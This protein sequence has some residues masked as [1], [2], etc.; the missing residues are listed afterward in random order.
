[1]IQGGDAITEVPPNR[2][3]LQSFY[4]PN[5]NRPG[6]TTARWG[7]FLDSID[8][9]DAHFFGI[10]PREA[11]KADPQQRLLLEVAYEAVEDAGL[12]L[13]Q[14]AGSSAGVFVGIS[15]F[16]YSVIQAAVTE[17]DEIDAYT[18]LGA[19]L[20]IAANRLSYFFDLHGPSLAVDTACS[21][22]LMATHLACQSLWRGETDLAVVGGVNAMLRPEGTMGFSKAG[23]LALDGHCKSFD[24]RGDGYVRAEGVGVLVLRPLSRALAT[25]EQIYAVI[26][27]TAA[28]QDGRTAG[29]AVPSGAAHEAMFRSALA[30][31]GFGPETVQY[32][33]AHGT[34]T[35]VGDPIEAIALG[36]VYGYGRTGDPCLIG[37]VKGN[38]GHLEA[39]AG[40]TGFIKAAIS[41]QHG[42]IPATNGFVTPNPQIPFTEL[43]LRVCDRLEPWP[44]TNGTPRRAAVSS[45]G[46]GGTNAHVIL[47]AAPDI[48]T[49]RVSSETAVDDS[50]V[51][52]LPL[53]GREVNAVRDLAAAYRSWLLEDRWR[54]VELVD[55]CY[56]ATTRRSQYDHRAAFVVCSKEELAEHLEAFLADQLEP[57]TVVGKTVPGRAL[58]VVFVCSGMGQ[59]WHA[60]GRQLIAEETVYREVASTIDALLTPLTGWSVLDELAQ[61]EPSSR[62]QHADVAQ[63]AIFMLQVGLAALWRSWGIEPAAIVGHSVGEVAA[64]HIAGAL[65]L[66]DAVQVIYHRSRL[67][68][69]VAGQ[70]TMLAVDLSLD[71]AQQIVDLYA[72]TVSMAAINAPASVTLSGEQTVLEVIEKRLSEG[73]AIC[74]FLKV[75]VPYH[76]PKMEP[77]QA[78][79]VQTLREI[80]PQAVHT[81]LFSTVT[82][83]ALL[84]PEV[85]ADYWWRNVRQPVQFRAAMAELI[86][87]K[88]RVF[89]E[90]GG[91]PVLRSA[92]AACLTEHTTE[93]LV[94][95]S[96]RRS[97]EERRAL[98]TSLGR[99]YLHGVRLDGRLY[100]NGGRRV[101]LPPYPW[102]RE[103]FW[104]E[105]T[106]SRNERLGTS[107]HPLLGRRVEAP[108]PT[109]QVDL[110]NA[111]L[112]YLRDHQVHSAVLFPAAGY[113][114]MALAAGREAFGATACVLEDIAYERALFLSEDAPPKTQVVLNPAQTEFEVFVR[115][116]GS[117]TSWTSHAKGRLR[118]AAGETPPAADIAVIRERC[119]HRIEPSVCY[120][121][122]RAIGLEY[123]PLFRGITAVW[124]GEREAFAEIKIAGSFEDTLGQYRVHPALLDACFQTLLAAIPESSPSHDIRQR[125]WLPEQIERLRFYDRPGGHA[126][127]HVRLVDIGDRSLRGDIQ[128]LD[129]LGQIHVGVEGFMC[130]AVE[131]LGRRRTG[132]YEYRW[133]LEPRRAEAPAGV[134]ATVSPTEL[135]GFL[136]E[137]VGRQREQL[138]RDAFYEQF[139]PAA[140]D[141]AAAYVARA[142]RSLG[143]DPD[144][145]N[146][147]PADQLA[148]ELGIVAQQRRQFGWLLRS[149]TPDDRRARR[150]PDQLWRELWRRFPD[151]HCELVLVRQCGNNL[152]GVLSGIADPTVVLFGDG[153]AST[154]EQLYQDSPTTRIYNRLMQRAVCEVVERFPP[155]LLRVLEIGAG[156]GGLTAQLLPLFQPERTRFVFSDISQLF[157]AQA[158]QR[159]RDSPFL[160][161]RVVDIEQDPVAQGL[162]P[163]S[164]DIVLAANALH[165]TRDLRV[166]VGHLKRLLAPGGL[167]ALI[168]GANPSLSV[169]LIF[170]LLTG[171]WLF[172]DADLRTDSPWLPPSAWRDLL[173]REGFSEVASVTDH[174]AEEEALH[175]VVLA[176]T[177]EE[178]DGAATE[179]VQPDRPGAWLIIGDGEGEGPRGVGDALARRLRARGAST[180]LVRYGRGFVD[181]GDG[182]YDI[183]LGNTGDMVRLLQSAQESVSGWKGIVHLSS[184]DAASSRS[185]TSTT[186]EEGTAYGCGSVLTLVQALQ[187]VGN[188]APSVWL[189]TRG[190][191]AIGGFAAPAEVAQ[192]PLWGIGRVLSIEHPELQC[193]LVDLGTGASEELD[194]V[195]RELMAP[196]AEDELAIRGGLTYVHRIVPVSTESIQGLGRAALQ[197][198]ESFRFEPGVTAGFERLR[199]TVV[200]RR[201][202]GP[203]ELEVKVEFTALNF[204]DVMLA[205]GLLPDEAVAGGFTGRTL[206]MECAGCVVRAG[207]GVHS[208]APGDEVI[209]C[210]AGAL[211]SH[212]T[213]DARFVLKKPERLTLEA[214]VTIP[215]AFLTAHYAL[216]TVG[217]IQSGER[218]L[219]HAG[220][221]GVGL[222]AI[223][224][225][226]RAGAAVFATAG[227]PEKRELL[228]ALGA[229][230]VTDSRSL[231]FRDAVLDATGGEGV[232]LVLNSLSGEAVN[233]SLE[234]LRPYGRFVEIGKRDI[235][236]NRNLR[237]RPFRHNISMHAVDLDR[238]C[239][240]RPALVSELFTEVMGTFET[241]ELHPLPRRVF[242]C[243]RVVDAFRY[244][245]QAKHVGK[246][247]I[248]MSARDGIRMSERPNGMR[249]VPDGT[250]LITGGLG[251]FGLATAEWLARRGA[252]HLLLMGRR[253]PSPA[254]AATM[255]ALRDSGVEIAVRS[256]DVSDRD[257]LESGLDAAR[258]TMPP[259]KGVVHTAMV[260]DDAP[261]R[262]LNEQRLRAVMAPKSMGAWNLHTLTLDQPLDFFIL[263]SS[264]MSMLGNAGQSNYAAGNAF[265]D[266]LACYRRQCGLPALT[267]NWGALAGVGYVSRNPEVLGRLEAAGVKATAPADMLEEMALLLGTEA[268]Q[269]A[270][271]EMDWGLIRRLAGSRVPPKLEALQAL[272]GDE[273]GATSE[274]IMKRLA[275]AE[276]DARRGVLEDYIRGHFSKIL[277]TTP[278]RIDVD[279]SLLSLGLDSLMAVEFR[280]QLHAAIGVNVPAQ[281]FLE[282]LS[283]A[284][285]AAYIADQLNLVVERSSDS[286]NS[287]STTA[288]V[289]PLSA[290]APLSTHINQLTDA[291][292]DAKL[293]TIISTSAPDDVRQTPS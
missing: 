97:Q 87:R 191:H 215:I 61:P 233:K 90:I 118:P 179:A 293:R 62:V 43:N 106:P 108:H 105:G 34:G 239:V 139:Q 237:M 170:G 98:L 175:V 181:H 196:D 217:R 223:Q 194:Q 3:R 125:P 74:R 70:G 38:I 12:T 225:A 75:D 200:P 150:D 95:P 22:S 86:A 92:T 151:A 162:E 89:L 44:E 56:S 207:A 65:S 163:Q 180:A 246:V 47:E 104:S 288:Q 284:G 111:G 258:T 260:L 51:Y 76:S 27:A 73:G 204:R 29:I 271:A 177:P 37:S 140:R 127:C 202:P 276:P 216:H 21:S 64:A 80:R 283:L 209:A 136:T 219:I 211:G 121:R 248:D 230:C 168:E 79:L 17:R 83:G 123:G 30:S 68:Q 144:R 266:A 172:E 228:M 154:L 160:E 281:K 241:G 93:G 218:V 156:T 35:S 128:V 231:A 72:P 146:V 203:G 18:N 102:Q 84:G 238:L 57:T 183:A 16:D 58:G 157:V 277:G 91:H 5:A 41:L 268:V 6:K 165:A 137:E 188:S 107:A 273:E 289:A 210:T 265:L 264:F 235:Y 279:Q 255:Q 247:L 8:D 236:E 33:E 132:L 199:A 159:F 173:R 145:H 115:D 60:M 32:V 272:S 94:L 52:L 53:S 100:P 182:T 50:R 195:V 143:W 206:G 278:A 155:R 28:N 205:M 119:P 158:E 254:A 252:R 96:L 1:L 161:Y 174:P 257:A 11:A 24:A 99:L 101:T 113:V 256:V 77:L 31:A 82:G 85:D 13:E 187:Q 110:G 122:F 229:S 20:C 78:E 19:A 23:M 269:V 48:A 131:N 71:A 197:R 116:S 280:S 201:A 250:Y 109:W 149:L 244:L 291:E 153:R 126:F 193:R 184:L 234:V 10:S 263:Y 275:E 40:V 81:P 253:A 124:G 220:T 176:T 185:L 36:R 141:V 114:E 222:A 166:T 169:T 292:V 186:L 245:A 213:V 287:A 261:L 259:L 120:S 243:D 226:Q 134:P 167:L 42:Q 270:V 290:P 190:V 46:F 221:G 148:R 242:R 164:F 240:E 133:K 251:G 59:Q 45:F 178:A 138:Q 39:A 7:G 26:R 227:S 274:A 286:S 112:D 129:E 55:L 249:I 142:F 67:Q 130:R 262:S 69:R 212:V 103:V 49:G 285:M 54:T 267:V 135:A 282:G 171:W 189:V 208:F 15:T 192:A 152:A 224:L 66:E 63:P 232:D 147:A 4:H 198:F 214:A 88:H 25:G 9:F 14:L 2:W 117:S